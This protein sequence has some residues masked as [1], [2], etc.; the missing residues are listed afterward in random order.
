M[1]RLQQLGVLE[2]VKFP[3]E[4]IVVSIENKDSEVPEEKQ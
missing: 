2:S 4:T 1:Y 3:S